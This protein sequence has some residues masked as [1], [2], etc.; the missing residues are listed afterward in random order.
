MMIGIASGQ[1]VEANMGMREIDFTTH[2][3][4]DPLAGDA[5][6]P[7]QHSHVAGFIGSAQEDDSAAELGAQI[8]LEILGQSP[9]WRNRVQ[10][11]EITGV[12]RA[13]ISIR[14]GLELRD[15]SAVMAMPDLGLPERI[16][17]LDG[18][19]KAG[20]LGWGKYRHHAQGQDK[21]D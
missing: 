4:I 18:V 5:K 13:N 16:K 17:A 15:V 20:L 11:S 7:A 21:V 14:D 8:Q 19:L 2:Q 12:A 9:S 6:A 10:A 3:S 1:S